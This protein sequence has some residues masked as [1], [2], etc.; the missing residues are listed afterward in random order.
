MVVMRYNSLLDTVYPLEMIL[1]LQNRMTDDFHLLHQNKTVLSAIYLATYAADDLRYSSRLSSWTQQLLCSILSSLNHD[2]HHATGQQSSTTVMTILILLFAAEALQDFEAVESHL[3]GIG[4]LLMIRDHVPTGLDAKLLFKIQQF[5]LR[6]ALAS[7]R[8]L[9]LA[10]E[11]NNTP[12]PPMTPIGTSDVP[13]RLE[14]YSP[15][16]IEAFQNMHA[17]TQDIKDAM[18][19]RTDLRWDDFQSQVSNIQKQLLH[20]TNS[21]LPDIDEAMRLGMLAFL[22]TLYRSP[23]RRQQLPEFHRQFEASCTKMQGKSENYRTFNTWVMMMGFI[24]AVEVSSP[25]A[26]A[27]W[28]AIVDS[29]LSWQT[30]RD[31][32]TAECLPWIKFIHDE[33]AKK[34]FNYLQAQRTS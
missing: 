21:C 26:G 15:W 25:L 20:P 31:R 32:I 1:D 6:L 13:Q 10:L 4:K 29:D 5:D 30:M 18:S 3:E 12:G 23:I 24:S 17:L 22:T 34:V 33:P 7:G 27:H 28:E 11:Y 14:I 16:V 2:L 8:P 19:T 9:H